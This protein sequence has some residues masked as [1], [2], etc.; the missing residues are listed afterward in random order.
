MIKMS[1]R[2]NQ[3]LDVLRG[4]W[5]F[6]PVSLAPFFLSLKKAAV[7]EHLR[8]GLSR[9]IARRVDQVFGSGDGTGSAEELD[10]GQEDL[11]KVDLSESRRLNLIHVVGDI[12]LG[13]AAIVHYCLL[14]KRWACNS[15]GST[16]LCRHNH[17]FR[18]F[19]VRHF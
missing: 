10:V 11:R 18:S 8:A 9:R 6:L 2:Q 13:N 3:T 5:Q 17:S 1:V 16:R 19:A 7:D 12:A 4:K 14:G 15:H